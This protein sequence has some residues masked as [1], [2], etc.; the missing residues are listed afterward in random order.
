MVKIELDARMEEAMYGKT[1]G[2]VVGLAISDE[3]P[4]N[5]GLRQGS[6]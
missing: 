3:F 5:I 2:T 1:K 6:A 4:V